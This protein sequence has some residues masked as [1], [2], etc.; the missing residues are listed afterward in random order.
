MLEFAENTWIT[1]IGSALIV[2][3]VWF[4]IGLLIGKR[5]ERSRARGRNL[6]QY[7][8]YP[9]VVDAQG[10]PVFD[11]RYSRLGVHYFLRNEDSVAACQLIF[12][13][14]QNCVRDLLD[15]EER[16][17]Y[18]KLFAKYK[19][20]AL[21]QDHGEFLENYRR[22]VRLLGRTF[23][24]MGIEILLHDLVNP[25]RSIVCIE[26][27]DVTGR[28]LGMGTTNL[29]IDL[30]RRRQL[31]QD[32]LN[33]ELNLGAR[34]FK[35]T[36]IPIV[37]EPYGIVAAICI[38]ID[39]NYVSDAV[40]KSVSEIDTFFRNY[41]LTELELDENILSRDEYARALQG[42]QHWKAA[43]TVPA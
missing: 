35:C 43:T 14:E 37:R 4:V 40:T 2:S 7:D 29:V 39:L 16:R 28:E 10:F 22:T 3:V 26:G 5:R 15:P 24:H 13:G 20:E 38:N 34:R 41:C 17:Q 36:T 32:K 8:F 19:G 23:R 25:S 33:Y 12:I 11:L 27:G 31:N 1:E 21:V 6:D 9:F 18:E 42:K 30:K